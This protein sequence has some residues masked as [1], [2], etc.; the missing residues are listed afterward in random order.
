MHEPHG[1]GGQ[2]YYFRICFLDPFQ[3]SVMAGFSKK[4]LKANRLK[5]TASN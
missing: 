4:S 3:G 5:Y 2:D 1:Y